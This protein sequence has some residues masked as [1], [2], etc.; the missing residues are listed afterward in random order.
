MPM[1]TAP[2]ARWNDRRLLLTAVLGSVAV[3]AFDVQLPLGIAVTALY[4]LVVLLGLFVRWPKYPLWAS[5]AVT[6]LTVAGALIS[7]EGGDTRLGFENRALTLVGVWVTA[8]LVAGD[9]ARGPGARR[10]G[11]EARRPQ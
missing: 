11:E 5:I 6:L 9:G 8:W 10:A 3:F 2:T 7:P 1:T 4:G